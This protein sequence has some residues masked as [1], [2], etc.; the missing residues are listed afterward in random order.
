[1]KKS[2]FYLYLLSIAVVL[3]FTFAVVREMKE[4][5]YL[6]LVKQYKEHPAIL[7]WALGNEWNL[8]RFY[9]SLPD[10]TLKHI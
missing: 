4:P 7:L 8:N 1:M 10:L 3:I 5:K 9:S 6:R 2:A